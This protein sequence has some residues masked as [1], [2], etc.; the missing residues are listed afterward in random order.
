MWSYQEKL[1]VFNQVT[2]EGMEDF[3]PKLFINIFVESFIHGNYEYE[4]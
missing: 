4:V 1:A 2:R 3:Y